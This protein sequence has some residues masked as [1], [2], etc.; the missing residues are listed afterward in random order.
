MVVVVVV[1]GARHRQ[2]LF[3]SLNTEVLVESPKPTHL[4]PTSVDKVLGG[5]GGPPPTSQRVCAGCSTALPDKV[6]V[7][8]SDYIPT[9]HS[10]LASS[11][12]DGVLRSWR[13]DKVRGQGCWG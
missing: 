3:L 12:P 9:H 2:G 4:F 7:E 13:R 1:T 8:M 5:A 10:H 6:K 11:P